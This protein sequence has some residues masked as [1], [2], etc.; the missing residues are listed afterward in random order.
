MIGVVHRLFNSVA[1]R[2]TLLKL[3]YGLVL[4]LIAVIA[5]FMRPEW[6]LAA[7]LVSMV[8]ELVQLWAFASLIKNKELAVRGPYVLTRNPMYLGRFFL[9]LGLLLL[10]ANLYLLVAYCILYYFY[11]INRVKREEQHLRQV[12]GQPYEEYCLKVNRFWPT[13]SRLGNKDTL[14]FDWKR[15][16]RNNGHW[17]LLS[18]L[19]VYAALFGYARY[20][21]TH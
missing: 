16:I 15:L 2:K 10:P 14:F 9:I 5:Y 7:F 13:L 12:L 21:V 4:A 1:L 18:T 19:I 6:W 11:M 3:R 8:G 17:N 20:L